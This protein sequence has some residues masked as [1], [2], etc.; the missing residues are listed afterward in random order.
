MVQGIFGL[1]LSSFVLVGLS[2]F[3]TGSLVGLR[4]GLGLVFFG[5]MGVFCLYEVL[6][7]GH[8]LRVVSANDKRKLV[9]KGRIKKSELSEFIKGGAGLGYP[10]QNQG[11]LRAIE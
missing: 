4:W 8:Y 1:L 7:K 11:D 5:A 3:V 2:L 10:I 6:Q 9:F